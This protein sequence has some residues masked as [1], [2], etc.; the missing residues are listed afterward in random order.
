MQ[1]FTIEH[2]ADL[3]HWSLTHFRRVF[4]EIMGTSPLDYINSTRIFKACNL[5]CSTEDSILDISEAVGF[6]SLSSF[7]RYFI[8]IMPMSPREYRKQFQKSDP[9]TENPSIQKYAG[10]LY[11]EK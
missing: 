7:N 4:H 5:L 8:K 2:L 9:Q 10:W 3:C 6:H 11:P 1:Q